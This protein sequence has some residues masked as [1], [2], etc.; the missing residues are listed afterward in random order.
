MLSYYGLITTTLLDNF[1]MVIIKC[2]TAYSCRIAVND[3]IRPN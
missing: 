1:G 3:L 2:V